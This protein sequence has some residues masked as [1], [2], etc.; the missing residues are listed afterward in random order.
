MHMILLYMLTDNVEIGLSSSQGDRTA[1]GDQLPTCP[2]PSNIC[3]FSQAKGVP[4]TFQ[5][6]LG[7]PLPKSQSGWDE[8]NAFFHSDS[9]FRFAS[10][11]I[12]D[13]D[14]ATAEFN[15]SIYNYLKGKFGTLR[16]T[17]S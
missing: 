3:A 12:E 2:P 6:L 7:V 1:V 9:L 17:D 10:G 15:R 5:P 4:A 14:L 11:K 16:G 13:L 8:M